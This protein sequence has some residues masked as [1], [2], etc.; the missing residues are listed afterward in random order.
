MQGTKFLQ[1]KHVYWP[2]MRSIISI[3]KIPKFECNKNVCAYFLILHYTRYLPLRITVINDKLMYNMTNTMWLIIV[4]VFAL[5]I[6]LICFSKVLFIVIQ[7]FKI[8]EPWLSIGTKTMLRTFNNLPSCDWHSV[9]SSIYLIRLYACI[10]FS[11]TNRSNFYFYL[12]WN[13]AAYWK[14]TRTHLFFW[15]A[16]I[17]SINAVV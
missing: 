7:N 2:V 11:R 16:H 3:S 6:W 5:T 8:N 9:K 14:C 13:N 12:K 1:I 4:L 17:N 10:V 15:K